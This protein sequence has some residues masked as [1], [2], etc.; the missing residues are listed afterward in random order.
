MRLGRRHWLAAL[1]I[2]ILAHAGLVA[3]L[4][5]TDKPVGKMN[6]GFGEIEVTLSLATPSLI[7]DTVSAVVAESTATAAPE[8]VEMVAIEPQAV[9]AIEPIEMVEEIVP[10]EDPTDYLVAAA[11]EQP[12]KTTVETPPVAVQAAVSAEVPVNPA[13]NSAKRPPTTP[14]ATTAA[15]NGAQN[16]YFS[17]LRAWLE[18]HKKYPRNAKIRRQEGTM[19]VRFIIQSSGN[20]LS[21]AVEQGS[22]FALLDREALEMLRRASPLPAIPEALGRDSLELVLP[23]A[24]YLR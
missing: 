24:F 22:G 11:S 20:L 10:A 4:L 2:A 3:M 12:T 14:S 9:E 5:V 8:I 19:T 6:P 13:V 17:H 15:V 16:D 7:V 23:V 1:A 18:R 21:Y